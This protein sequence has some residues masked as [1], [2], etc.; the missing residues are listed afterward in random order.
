MKL[1][2]HFV[3]FLMHDHFQCFA[4]G[5]ET[6]LATTKATLTFFSFNHCAELR[7]SMWE[8]ESVVFWQE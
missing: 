2:Q 1:N 5:S 3:M 8:W 7:K 6:L 4:D